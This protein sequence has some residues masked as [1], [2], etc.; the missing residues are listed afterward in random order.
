MGQSTRV[1]LGQVSS[2]GRVF[3]NGVMGR[4]M[5]VNGLM[6][7]NMAVGYGRVLREKVILGS[8]ITVRL[9]GLECTYLNLAIVTR[10][11]S[12]T[13]KNKVLGHSVTVMARLM[14]AN[15]VEI[16]LMAK[17]NISGRTETIIRVS[18]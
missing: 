16:V 7:K 6:A 2:V 13:P 5:K 11:N 10:D 4:F 12:K 3:L 18:L 9:K 15:T 17:G 8:G 14:W 1:N